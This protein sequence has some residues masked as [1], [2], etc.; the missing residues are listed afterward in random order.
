MVVKDIISPAVFCIVNEPSLKIGKA[1]KDIIS[2]VF[3]I[4]NAIT[5]NWETV[6]F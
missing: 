2:P 5:K 6:D 3:C 4:V 1:V